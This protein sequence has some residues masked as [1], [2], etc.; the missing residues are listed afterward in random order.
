M[1]SRQAK[2]CAII[3]CFPGYERYAY[4]K[5]DEEGNL[6]EQEQYLLVANYATVISAFGQTSY[7][8]WMKLSEGVKE[9]ALTDKSCG[10]RHSAKTAYLIAGTAC[11]Q[12]EFSYGSGDEWNV[13]IELYFIFGGM[14]GRIFTLLDYDTEK[15]ELL[16]GSLP[17]NGMRMGEIRKLLLTEQLFTSAG[18]L[19][20]GGGIG[21][22]TTLCLYV[23]LWWSICRKSIILP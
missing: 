7:Q 14:F 20:A 4:V 18:P 11:R 17:G 2:V 1:G 8:V 12:P 13:Y 16:L 3:D 9:A 19:L 22:V 5:R 15:R 23:C 10:S 6:N 21:A